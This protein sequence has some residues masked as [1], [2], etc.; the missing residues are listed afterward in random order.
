MVVLDRQRRRQETVCYMLLKHYGSSRRL[1]H[2]PIN[3]TLLFQGHPG[4]E[5][6]VKFLYKR[7]AFALT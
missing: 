6:A 3:P 1:S 5:I 7:W 2:Q 4:V